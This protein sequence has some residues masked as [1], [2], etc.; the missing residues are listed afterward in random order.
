MSKL[1]NPTIS[2]PHF[3]A[4]AALQIKFPTWQLLQG[5][6]HSATGSRSR[7]WEQQTA[8]ADHQPGEVRS[9]SPPAWVLSTL[10]SY[11]IIHF[12]TGD[13][14]R[15]SRAVPGGGVGTCRSSHTTSVQHWVST[16]TQPCTEPHGELYTGCLACA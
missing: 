15:L 6:Q 13:W 9:L 12:L 4:A 11:V 7:N 16:D 8:E 1:K 14:W 5:G 10:S 3:W 2:F